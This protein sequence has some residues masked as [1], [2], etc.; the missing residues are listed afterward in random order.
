AQ[1]PGII[2]ATRR[3]GVRFGDR[4]C[5]GARARSGFRSRSTRVNAWVAARPVRR[6]PRLPH[7]SAPSRGVVTAD[8]RTYGGLFAVTLATLVYEILLTRVFSVTMW[9][10]YAFMAV[11]LALFGMTVGAIVVYAFPTAFPRDR[12]HHHLALSA[13]L[14]GLASVTAL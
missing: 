12:T 7:G 14:F 4:A 2:V 3:S 6:G 11:S 9:Y 13:L 10:H 1:L 8:V 5:R